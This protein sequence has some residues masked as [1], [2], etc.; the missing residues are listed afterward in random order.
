M[1][2]KEE[3]TDRFQFPNYSITNILVIR[4]LSKSHNEVLLFSTNNGKTCVEALNL[5]TL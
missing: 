5:E 1:I 2:I 3:K 4:I